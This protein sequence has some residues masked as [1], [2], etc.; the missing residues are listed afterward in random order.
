MKIEAARTW[1]KHDFANGDAFGDL[2]TQ[3]T[4]FAPEDSTTLEDFKT[5]YRQVRSRITAKIIEI[6]LSPTLWKVLFGK[7]KHFT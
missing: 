3:K 6:S 1:F 4:N 7:R 5:C 2:L